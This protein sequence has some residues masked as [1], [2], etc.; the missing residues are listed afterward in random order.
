VTPD[1][2]KVRKEIR[3]EGKDPQGL[4]VQIVN[5]SQKCWVVE[6]ARKNQG[7]MKTLHVYILPPSAHAEG[8][9]FERHIITKSEEATTYRLLIA[10][11]HAFPNWPSWFSGRYPR[12]KGYV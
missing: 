8:F 7:A 2:E 12:K 10:I 5:T 9:R 6:L 4:P 1:A 11:E 3:I